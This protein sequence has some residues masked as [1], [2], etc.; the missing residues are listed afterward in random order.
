MF[1]D[2]RTITEQFPRYFLEYREKNS[3]DSIV[4]WDYRTTSADGTWSGNIYD[5]YLKII[6]RLTDNINI[7]FRLDS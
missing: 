6:N 1:G 3:N 2:E 4:R 7:P 5:F